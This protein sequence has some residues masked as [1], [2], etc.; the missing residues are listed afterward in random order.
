MPEHFRSRTD[1][2][3]WLIA[4]CPRPAIVR[5]LE[6]GKVEFLGGFNSIPPSNLPG[7]IFK[8][9]TKNVCI[10][11]NDREHKYEIRIVKRIP[12]EDW[13]GD[14][15]GL[16]IPGRIHNGDKPE[17]YKELWNVAKSNRPSEDH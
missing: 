9:K 5:A 15:C 14:F 7:W 6:M 10:L 11:A 3:E 8:T 1:M 2:I 13:A 16:I 17:E 12:W 4:N